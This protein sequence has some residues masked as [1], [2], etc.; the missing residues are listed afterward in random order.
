MS[1]P[2]LGPSAFT[3]RRKLSLSISLTLYLPQRP[4]AAIFNV[5]TNSLARHTL[6]SVC[7]LCSNL[8]VHAK[9]EIS[10]HREI[11]L[12]FK[13]VSIIHVFVLTVCSTIFIC[14]SS[15]IN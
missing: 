15:R 14:C 12:I 5:Q 8:N 6:V 4:R 7:L 10:G 9:P 2:C 3:G 11:Q 13:S 1:E